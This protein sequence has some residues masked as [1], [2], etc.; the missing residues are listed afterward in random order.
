MSPYAYPKAFSLLLAG[1]SSSPV[2]VPLFP[3]HSVF[4]WPEGYALISL[5]G[6][7]NLAPAYVPAYY[8]IDECKARKQSNPYH[9]D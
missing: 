9:P 5:D 4:G 6:V 1:F 2:K 8:E 3:A 7:S